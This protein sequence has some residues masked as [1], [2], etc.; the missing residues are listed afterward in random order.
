MTQSRS[1]DYIYNTF[2]YQSLLKIDW[3]LLYLKIDSR[4]KIR[5]RLL[6]NPPTAIFFFSYP[7]Y[8][9]NKR[10]TALI[11]VKPRSFFYYSQHEKDFR[12]VKS[13]YQG[14]AKSLF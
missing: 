13:G 9:V 12:L 3:P 1:L 2:L 14:S 10:S 5:G 6:F 11:K 4:E 7:T 8:H